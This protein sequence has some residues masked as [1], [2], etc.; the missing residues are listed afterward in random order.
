MNTTAAA[1]KAG[2][3]VATIRTWCRYGAVTATKRAGRWV[4]DASSLTRRIHLGAQR[5]TRKATRMDMPIVLTSRTTRVPGH[6]GAVGPAEVLKAAFENREPVTLSGKFAGEV[7]YLGHRRQTYGDYG[8]TLK[9]IGE[10]RTWQHNGRT[11]AVYLVD[12]DRLDQAPRLAQIVAEAEARAYAEAAE[13]E[14]R[15]AAEEAAYL[16]REDY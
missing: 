13:A 7:V 16:D 9:T 1:A 14:A 6:I 5:R 2:V 8:I 4:I 10:D 12:L 15:A 3:T 11:L